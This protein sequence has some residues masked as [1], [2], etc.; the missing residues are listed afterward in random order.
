MI[1]KLENP[2]KIAWGY[3]LWFWVMVPAMF[4]ALPSQ[5]V[6]NVNLLGSLDLTHHSVNNSIGN[7]WGFCRG[8]REYA[9]VAVTDGGVAII[10][11]TDPANP[12]EASF[13]P[14][15]PNTDR[16]Y[17]AQPYSK[18]YVYATMQP[19]PL[20][21]ID[22]RDPYNAVEAGIYNQNF[23]E[24]YKP[25][26]DERRE[27]LYLIDTQGGPAGMST[28]LLDIS[29]P[30]NPV[31]IGY[32]SAGYHH[33]YV[34]NDT[35]YGFLF[36]KGV[37][38]LDVADPSNITLIANFG[39]VLPKTHS[40]WLHDSGKYLTVDHEYAPGEGPDSLG[41]H[42]QIWDVSVLPASPVLKSQY[43][44]ATNHTGQASL[45]HS[46]WYRNLIY[47][48][49]WTEGLRIVDASDPANPVEVGV[50]DWEDPNVSGI[51]RGAWGVFPYLPSR[52]LLVSVRTYG[53]YILD[54]IQD[55]PGI[56]H[57]PVDTLTTATAA[58]YGEFVHINGPG[59]DAGKSSVF[60]RTDM[61]DS[62]K[63]TGVQR[64]ND[65]TFSF[66][67]PLS[68][69]IT[70][71]EYYIEA[72]DSTGQ[73]TRAPGLAPFLDWYETHIRGDAGLP[74]FM[75]GYTV[76]VTPAGIRLQWETAAE[77]DNAG[78]VILRKQVTEDR[79]LSIASYETEPSLR[80][81]GSAVSGKR[82]EYVD[83]TA[84]PGRIQ[85]LIRSV[86]F[87]GRTQD[88]GP[89]EVV[90]QKPL[91]PLTVALLPNFP[92]PFNRG[93]TFQILVPP[94]H[95]NPRQPRSVRLTIYDLRGIPVATIFDGLLMPG[96]HR[97]V[98]EGR[99]DFLN[100][101]PSGVYFAVLTVG[102]TVRVQPITCVK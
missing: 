87:H 58:L 85:Y 49:Y 98:W 57:T 31:Q 40:G 60:W 68:A 75:K 19:G 64:V 63:S 12:V 97:F 35:A 82:Y 55:G 50:Y 59:I 2:G 42:L 34:R 77:I 93:T 66:S 28:I 8:G 9:V 22:V 86:D 6:K 96:R 71:V 76:T 99:T 95:A 72:A 70:R 56:R 53:L 90:L 46:Y 80:G 43:Y 23:T 7:V 48:S 30:V 78:F 51:Y 100:P 10:D 38:V 14:K 52:N 73:K 69:G 11:V 74:V 37:D 1:F 47:M 25:W 36:N 61:V 79:F 102:Q 5:I 20:Q 16:L 81:Q 27:R 32:Y 91:L 84:E 83:Q 92:N 18:G 33:I 39:T 13:V 101:I 94:R 17:Y 26:V 21:I 29:D 65:S 62:W 54:Y 3:W 89:L 24:A 67:I 45:H 41:G 88:F 44:T 15:P 4:T